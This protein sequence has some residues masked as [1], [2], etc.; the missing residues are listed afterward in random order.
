MWKVAVP[1]VIV[2]A[3]VVGWLFWQQHRPVPL[4][5]SG[6]IECDEVRVGSRV[7]GRVAEVMVQEGQTVKAGEPLFRIEPYDLNERLAKAQ[8]QAAASRAEL[9]RLKEGYRLDEI[10]QAQARRD[11]LAATLA[12][13]VAGPR[14]R[15]IQI[16]V[17]RLESAKA[18]YDLAVT[19]QKRMAEM[20]RA[21]TASQTEID[22]ADRELQTTLAAQRV[23]D[24]ELAL[25]KEGT[26]KEEIDEARASLNEAEAALDLL[27]KGYRVQ[28]IEQAAAQVQA[29]E[30]EVATI[31]KQLDE[32][33]VGASVN[34][35]VETID[36]RPGDLV[37]ANGPAVALLD[38]S[39]M[40]VRAYVPEGQLSRVKL[41]QK[42]AIRVD[43][44]P[45][46]KFAGRVS[47]VA[48]D[49]EFTPRNVQTVEERSKQVFRIK[50]TL[51]SGK[52][53][54]RVGMMAD[55]LLDEPVE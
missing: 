43:G 8:A 19:Q 40:W 3:V 50:V 11:K 17:A 15:E 32:L 30:A 41:G 44:M 33:T 42:L 52:E 23:A 21:G 4:V 5:V 18:N 53:R 46:E 26:R 14:P 27:K 28:E 37:A 48:T 13:L 6:F 1:L 25:L 31:K 2:A 29:N 12:K 22:R 7:G 9:A 20:S 10:A 51:E 49:A 38:L 36:L 39:K 55:V 47:F 34:S 24:E 16:A 54:L 45:N 35:V